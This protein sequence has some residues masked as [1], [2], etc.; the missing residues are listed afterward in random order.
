M[1]VGGF[2]GLPNMKKKKRKERFNVH[3]GKDDMNIRRAIASSYLS[4]KSTE[5]QIYWKILSRYKSRIL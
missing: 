5:M 4:T 3:V 2:P 1:G